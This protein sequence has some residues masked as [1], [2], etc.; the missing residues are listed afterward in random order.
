[1]STTAGTLNRDVNVT[2]NGVPIR[3]IWHMLLYAWREQRLL[4]KWQADVE[5]APTLDALLSQILANL[6]RQRIRIGLGR[7]YRPH[8]Q[9]IRGIRGRVDFNTSLK[10][11]TFPEGKAHCRFEAFSS[12]VLKNQ[13]I[14]ST[15]NA[16][17]VRGQL[18]THKKAAD[19]L[20]HD[21][22]CL[23]RD[24]D[25][26]EMIEL[27]PD[28]VRRQQQQRDDHD[29]RL[30]LLI[31]NLI[32]QHLMPTQSAGSS[33][34]HNIDLDWKF[35]CRVFEKFVANFYITHLTDWKVRPQKT[36]YWPA[37]GD[38]SFLPIMKPDVV[39]R[40][41]PTKRIAVIDTKLTAKSLATGQHGNQTF[42][43]DHVFQL[44]GYVQS[45]SDQSPDWKSA[46]GILLYPTV[47]RR[48]CETVVLQGHELR[49]ETVD[50]TKPWPQIESD[51]LL[52]AGTLLTKPPAL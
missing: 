13:I 19:G 10:R 50:L 32:V 44:Y 35:V 46:T 24:L 4:D 5:S 8:E 51:L 21:L 27:K 26:I 12:N 37:E 1:M 22:R 49:W 7:D 40:H 52:L 25:H 20:R 39:M 47:T 16:M 31:C 17:S 45:Q 28:V 11:M 9:T 3:N 15:L 36:L 6:I 41:K 48:L 30:M 23:V 33:R 38:C 42:N 29:Y 18:G 34:L 2:T 43:R 14:R